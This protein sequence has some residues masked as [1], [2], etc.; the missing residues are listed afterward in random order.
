MSGLK[1][2]CR[3]T[4]KWCMLGQISHFCR[5]DLVSYC[6]CGY[7]DLQKI[8]TGG[9]VPRV[10]WPEIVWG[11]EARPWDVLTK[12]VKVVERGSPSSKSTMATG[13][14]LSSASGVRR[15]F[16]CIFSLMATLAKSLWGMVRG[17][18]FDGGLEPPNSPLLAMGLVRFSSSEVIYLSQSQ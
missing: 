16:W 9:S 8:V 7:C 13:S 6:H 18:I 3:Y 17:K 5:S 15:R 4:P 10:E 1:I 11:Q 2:T 12:G 14:I